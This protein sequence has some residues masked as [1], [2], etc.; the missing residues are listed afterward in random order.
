MEKVNFGNFDIF[1]I[2]KSENI[3]DNNLFD[4]TTTL[5][6]YSK[7]INEVRKEKIEKIWNKK[8]QN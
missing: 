8:T 7:T 6:H 2:F 4:I 3:P 1:D 5:K